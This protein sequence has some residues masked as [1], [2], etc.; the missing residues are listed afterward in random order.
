[1]NHIFTFFFFLLG[2]MTSLFAQPVA[3][4][5][6]FPLTQCNPPYE[7]TFENY[8]QGDT[9]WHWDF[10]D[11]NTSFFPNPIHLYSSTGTFTVTLISYGPT[12]SDTLVRSNYV[13]T[14]APPA[15]PFVNLLSD[16][17]NCGS[18][19]RFVATG[20]AEL[21]WYDQT[22]HIV[23]VG[24]TLDLPV[25]TQ[26]G[27][28][29]VQSEDESAP[30]FVG[31][32]DPDSVGTGGNFNGDQAMIFNVLGDIRLKS[33]LVV[34]Q[35]AGI[36]DFVLEDTFGVILKTVSVFIPDGK[37]RL[38]LNLELLPGNYRLRGNG[39]NLFRNNNGGTAFPYEI[40]GLIE[41][42]GST[43]GN[44]FYYYFYDWE[45]TT[46][47]RSNRVA[48]N[49][50]THG[51]TPAATAQDTVTVAC[52]SPAELIA[53]A[54]SAVY[55]YD[56]S[57]EEVGRGDTL[58]LPFVGNS[59]HYYA[60]NIEQSS[61]FHVGPADQD[62]LGNG[63]FFNS[64]ENSWLYFRVSAPITLQSVW[65]QADVAG[66]RSFEIV[67]GNGDVVENV[68]AMLPAGKSR[69]AL[70]IELGVGSYQIGGS[71]L[72]LFRNENVA[73]S[74][75]YSLA[76]V[77]S[78][79][80]SSAG[81]DFYN[82][83]YDW[84]VRTL[85]QSEADSVYLAVDPGPAPVLN[86]DSVVL[87][88]ADDA[89]FIATGTDVLWYDQND[90]VIAA[91]DSLKL[92]DVAISATY[93]ARNV[94]A[95]VAQT[96]G[97]WNAASLGRGGYFNIPFPTGLQ[98]EVYSPIRL[99]SVWVDAAS[100]GNRDII[101]NDGNGNPLQI[102]T[103]NI[104]AGRGRIT[105]DLELEPGIYE[106]VGANMDLYR[107][108]DGFA[109]PYTLSGLMAITGQVGF[110]GGPGGG[111]AY[112]Y[113]Y[114]WEVASLCKSDPVAATVRVL[115]LA[116]PTIISPDTLC[117]GEQAVFTASSASASWY[118]PNGAFLGSGKSIQTLPLTTGG[119][120]IA[121]SEN[122]SPLQNVGPLNGNSLGA[123]TYNSPQFPAYLLFTVYAPVRINSFLV[124]AGLAG[125]RDIEL[126]DGAGNPIQTLSVFIPSG[127][128]RVAVGLELQ[129]GTYAIGGTGLDLFRNTNGAIFPFEIPALLSITGSTG[130]RP[131]APLYNYF[132][133]WEVQELPCSSNDVSFDIFVKQQLRSSF[134]YLQNVAVITFT[135][136]SS[137]GTSYLWEFGDGNTATTRTALHTYTASG[138]YTVTLTVTDGGCKAVSRQTL[139]I[140]SGVAIDPL[141][142][143]SFQ[144]FPNPGNG[145]FTVKAETGQL[146]N[147]RIL[148]FDYTGRQIFASDYRETATFE[149]TIDLRDQPAGSYFL[150][151]QLGDSRII[152]KYILIK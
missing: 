108:T 97:P 61:A 82:F 3:D 48:V 79:T 31:P 13:T 137:Q 20:A 102:K 70:N 46:F 76:G 64:I 7:V 140:P 94:E 138:T 134:T 152:K 122:A 52:G 116:S 133:D 148:V 74:Y 2:S 49:V 8:S 18:S 139:V 23:S 72:G 10:G 26:S 21:V 91:G 69:I 99:Q 73:T 39:V 40:P 37:S 47:C 19:A 141:W 106:L 145:H 81:R 128:R 33:I 30:M 50:V 87:N 43:A 53:T 124:D 12:G 78:I 123:G 67:D 105:L 104:P 110:G 51:I 44:G 25:V 68:R 111:A 32:K 55:W 127:R 150:Q 1:M 80:G 107:S 144:L 57:D 119:T 29:Y 27:T 132:Y 35:G 149:E 83:F 38:Y 136:T 9:A 109:F 92:Q 62:S 63:A 88:C 41:I 15:D 112:Y 113:F 142:A 135:N 96:V 131:G 6:G 114:D 54:P 56:S 147:M 71:A 66:N 65:V 129:P 143:K 16:T 120:F 28:F 85:C 14:L 86:Q 34:A 42:T 89:L 125:Q 151:F 24:D 90:I 84:E 22:D 59:G 100:S 118:G 5:G 45:V 103:V 60:R 4:F 75:P 36:R 93:Y 11:G 130:G 17:V 126:L 95:G 58:R 121:K 98:F 101:L 146:S 77:V 117:Y 115:P